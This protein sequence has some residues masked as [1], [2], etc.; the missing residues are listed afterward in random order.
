M[1]VFSATLALKKHIKELR[2][3]AFEGEPPESSGVGGIPAPLPEEERERFVKT[4]NDLEHIVDELMEKFKPASG[5][6]EA[7]TNLT[8]IW[9]SILLGKMEGIVESIRPEKLEKSRGAMPDELKTHLDNQTKT[10]LNL[11]RGLRSTYT[12]ARTS[13]D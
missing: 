10:L 2:K 11:I 8:Y 1:A 7:S 13:R 3:I 9:L 5:T 4:L 12:T 6:E